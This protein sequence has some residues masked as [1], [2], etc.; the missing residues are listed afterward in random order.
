MT[1]HVLQWTC[2]HKQLQDIMKEE[3]KM[4]RE[5]LSAMK[6]E[7]HALM[8][9]NLISKKVIKTRRCF[10]NKQLKILQKERSS[11]TKSIATTFDKDLYIHHFNSKNF[12]LLISKDGDNA[13]ETFH[14]RDQI[15]HLM[16]NIKQ[17]KDRIT[18][19]VKSGDS[20]PYGDPYLSLEILPSC[21]KQGNKRT[22]TINSDDPSSE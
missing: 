18:I 6:E 8:Q 15:L 1:N 10:L 16:K 5:V 4:L 2:L 22:Q 12:N 14:L 20:E 3:L 17:L 19:L 21:K 7:E 13:V 9:R 11:L